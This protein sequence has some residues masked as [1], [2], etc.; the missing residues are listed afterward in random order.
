MAQ[1]ERADASREKQAD[2]AGETLTEDGVRLRPLKPEA[3]PAE[4]SADELEADEDSGKPFI[5]PAAERPGRA[6]PRM[7][8]IDEFPLPAQNQARAA[9]GQPP[10]MGIE[11]QKKKSNFFKR[12]ASAGLGIREADEE[13]GRMIEPSLEARSA[14]RDGASGNGLARQRRVAEAPRGEAAVRTEKT[15]GASEPAPGD[16]DHLEIPAFLRR[17]AN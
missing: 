4:L 10:E 16:D 15:A 14:P 11:A 13:D 2:E 9:R 8:R 6:H 3:A 5:P 1:D 12:L 17:Q 7:P